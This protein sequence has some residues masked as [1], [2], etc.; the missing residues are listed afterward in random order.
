MYISGS[1]T[2]VR[3]LMAD[4]SSTNCICWSTRWCSARARDC[5]PR[6]AAKTSLS[7]AAH[8]AFDNG[9]LHLTYGPAAR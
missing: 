7:L 4:G 3:A 8:E 5:S 9:V 2:L 6:G 1:G